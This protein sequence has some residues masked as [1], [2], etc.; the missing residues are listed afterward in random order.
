MLAAMPGSQVVTVFSSGPTSV[1]PLPDWD[2]ECR[3]FKSGD[4]VTAIRANE[5]DEA[6]GVLEAG[7]HRLGFWD[8][9]YRSGSRHRLPSYVARVLR[10]LR[11]RREEHGLVIEISEKLGATVS[12][13]DL[14]TWFVPLGVLHPDHKLLTRVVLQLAREMPDKRWILYEDLPYALESTAN[15][16]IAIGAVT[17]AGFTLEP[18]PFDGTVDEGRKRAA[19]GFYRSQLQGLGGRVE[20]AVVGPERYHLLVLR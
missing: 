3:V 15:R 14:T 8:L 11:R 17:A 19:V 13:L 4:D 12:A 18:V 16:T 5:D 20:T 1:D 2:R 6:L 10:A 9:Q 7:A